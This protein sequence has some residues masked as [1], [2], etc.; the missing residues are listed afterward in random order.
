MTVET[1]LRILLILG[2]ATAGSV[3]GFYMFALAN[4]DERTILPSTWRPFVA[5][6][7]GILCGAVAWRIDLSW[8][9]PALLVLP[10]FG[11]LLAAVDLRTKL[12]P[13]ALVRPF[14]LTAAVLLILAAL[15]GDAWS[16]LLGAA[17][18]G[19]SLFAIYL[20]LA[21]IS[22][23]GLGMGDVKLAGVLGLYAGYVGPAAWTVTAMGGFILGAV[24]GI[25]LLVFTHS[26]RK[27]AFPFGPAMLAA[28][29]AAVTVWS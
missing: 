23:S 13:N 1:L 2:S 5:A 3:L 22:P 14:F 4:R 20:V 29:I 26:S 28:S 8:A 24:F 25:L 6:V 18:G 7:T 9:L 10:L 27:A 19:A 11:V 15:F 16:S 17:I 12:L 21:L